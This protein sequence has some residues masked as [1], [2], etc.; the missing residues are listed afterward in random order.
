MKNQK[1]RPLWNA[2]IPIAA[3][4]L[5]VPHLSAQA[6]APFKPSIPRTWDDTAM[7]TLEVP[8]AN[9]IG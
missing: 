8:L 6:T 3:L 1:M 2:Q 4:L 7:A 9:P 5:C